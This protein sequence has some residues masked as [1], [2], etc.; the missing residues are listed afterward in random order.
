M[1]VWVYQSRRGEIAIYT[2]DKR[3]T[4]RF[5][6]DID[7]NCTVDDARKM[8]LDV[9][10]DPDEGDFSIDD[11]GSIVLQEV[12]GSDNWKTPIK[13]QDGLCHAY[14]EYPGYDCLQPKD[15]EG[16]HG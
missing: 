9:S 10:G 16:N 11:G 4:A 5:D 3:S 6:Q 1:K 15:H 8:G 14:S 13:T 2:E 12:F 7:N